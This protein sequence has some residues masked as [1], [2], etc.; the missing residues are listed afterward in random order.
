MAP[1][2]PSDPLPLPAAVSPR[3]EAQS[4]APAKL[5]P[6]QLTAYERAFALLVGMAS[7][8]DQQTERRRDWELGSPTN[9]VIL[10]DGGR[11]AGKTTVLLSVL[12]R[13][14]RQPAFERDGLRVH[15]FLL[16]LLDLHPLPRTTSILSHVAARL[17]PMDAARTS[18]PWRPTHDAAETVRTRWRAFAQNAAL[19]WDSNVVARSAHLDAEA[20]AHELERATS[21]WRNIGRV[22]SE[23]IDELCDARR[24]DQQP[25]PD[26]RSWRPLFVLPI[27]D[28]DMNPERSLEAMELFRALSHPR[29]AFVLTGDSKL[30][31]SQLRASYLGRLREPLRHLRLDSADLTAT[32]HR[33]DAIRLAYEYFE[34]V[35][36]PDQRCQLPGFDAETRAEAHEPLRRLLEL[37]TVV[38]AAEESSRVTLASLLRN[39]GLLGEALPE[40]L[41]PL[42]NLQRLIEKDVG[43]LDDAAIGRARAS[44]GALV[45]PLPPPLPR[46]HT[47]STTSAPPRAEVAFLWAMRRIWRDAVRH[48]TLGMGGQEMLLRMVRLDYKEH[49]LELVTGALSLSAMYQ[50]VE[51]RAEADELRI[52]LRR[53]IRLMGAAMG[54]ERPGEPCELSPKIVA[55]FELAYDVAVLS[56]RA[57]VIGRSPLPTEHEP[58]VVRVELPCRNLDA[59]L[60]LTWPLPRLSTFSAQHRLIEG[61]I[62]RLTEDRRGSPSASRPRP[63]ERDCAVR[64]LVFG[65]LIELGALPPGDR[66]P[67]WDDL[68][69]AVTER[70]R[71]AASEV[72]ETRGLRE[73]AVQSHLAD[74]V[75]EAWAITGLVLLAAPESGLPPGQAEHLL[76]VLSERFS[77][78]PIGAERSLWDEVRARAPEGRARRID[79]ALKAAT[80][81]DINLL[82]R[83]ARLSESARVAEVLKE[84]DDRALARHH[85]WFKFVQTE[86]QAAEERK[87]PNVIAQQ[88][89]SRLAATA[90]PPASPPSAPAVTSLSSYIEWS[91]VRKGLLRRGAREV[92]A[93]IGSATLPLD[94]DIPREELPFSIA[95]AWRSTLKEASPAALF[96]AVHALPTG[97][98]R[99]RPL[100]RREDEDTR[101]LPDVQPAGS[102]EARVIVRT[103]VMT[104]R[105]PDN[106][107]GELPPHLDLFYRVVWDLATDGF[108]NAPRLGDPY[109]TGNLVEVA[110]SGREGGI[111][112]PTMPFQALLD[113]EMIDEN[114]TRLADNILRPGPTASSMSPQ[115]RVDALAFFLVELIKQVALRRQAPARSDFKS[116]PS[117]AQW[118]RLMGSL[119]PDHER[120]PDGAERGFAFGGDRRVAFQ[121]WRARVPLLAAPECGLSQTA[122]AAI[123]RGVFDGKKDHEVLRAQLRDYRVEHVRRSGR[124]GPAAWIAKVD[125]KEWFRDHPWV[126]EVMSKPSEPVKD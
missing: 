87:D 60:S 68:L 20:Y 123:L 105:P 115:D 98:L 2:S 16:P 33:S 126:R 66:I 19:G 112:W 50:E 47:G 92:E 34:R 69:A 103:Y 58:G 95:N 90:L 109:V 110:G 45:S 39:N 40:R 51:L 52:E 100:A 37:L 108:I 101:T 82:D 49:T 107:N 44:V 120:T 48:A 14:A 76:G 111:P 104:V 55:A 9:R 15:F 114:W 27:D 65:S 26:A 96:E 13:I 38:D 12:D 72:A 124:T 122:A 71:R 41:R 73:R 119:Y 31:E 42:I 21:S 25:P 6:Q 85:P 23:L 84:V 57:R 53:P 36:P 106:P 67:P 75:I 121:D 35:I 70:M 5:T 89:L 97:R 80:R 10:I 93:V 77:E 79:A 43:A 17:L 3:K 46:P 54:I 11:G 74:D 83:L 22:F 78:V 99:V 29:L 7:E 63:F 118:R 125:A 59:T 8:E 102:P 116:A 30:F 94:G 18:A 1:P 28:A 56:K 88:M 91:Q 113:L 32:S 61:A 81:G 86:V 24:K 4:L 62:R 117:E 64:A